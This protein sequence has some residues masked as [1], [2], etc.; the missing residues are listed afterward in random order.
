VIDFFGRSPFLGRKIRPAA[1]FPFDLAHLELERV[2]AGI[3]SGMTGAHLEIPTKLAERLGLTRTGTELLV[4]NSGRRMIQVAVI[5]EVAAAGL[6]NCRVENAKVWFFD[7]APILIGNRFMRETG[8][9]VV[10]G[11]DGPRLV[12]KGPSRS[13][14]PPVFKIALEHGGRTFEAD[15]LFD[16]AWESSDVALPAA[17]A[18]ALGL[19]NFGQ[20]SEP[21][22]TGSYVAQVSKLDRMWV[23]DQ[24][25][26][27]V[28]GA[29]VKIL[30]RNLPFADRIVVGESFFRKTGGTVGYGPEGPF[31]SC[32]TS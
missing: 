8:A 9:Q 30:P 6:P 18:E 27:Q 15:A 22:P 7:G 11:P 16:T 25:T 1:S 4:D 13:D 10:Y 21:T 19:P 29:K 5:R 3:D 28:T 2:V 12:C 23:V 17:Y 20:E 31:Y 26:C 14:E 32:G 24:P